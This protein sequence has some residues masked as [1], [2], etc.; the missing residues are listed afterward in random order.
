ML[1]VHING[2]LLSVMH[3]K[4]HIM[5]NVDHIRIELHCEMVSFSD[6]FNTDWTYAFDGPG[7]I[8]CSGNSF[9]AGLYRSDGG[10]LNNIE[11]GVCGPLSIEYSQSGLTCT[12]AWW[13]DSFAT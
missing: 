5:R 10:G 9:L 3:G 6:H 1:G 12:N 8:T 13:W 11:T 4:F 7:T 2:S